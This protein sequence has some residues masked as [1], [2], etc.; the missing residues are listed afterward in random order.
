[1]KLG[2]DTG[3]VVNWMSVGG[4]KPEVG[5][6]VTILHWTDRSAGTIIEVGKN[7]RFVMVQDDKQWRT[8]K[9]GFSEA[10]EWATEPNPEGAVRKYTLRKDGSYR[11]VGSREAL[12][13]GARNPYYDPCF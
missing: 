8:D 2:R 5:M 12:T 6:G 3:S 1:M 13:I 11:L 10:Q 9:N 4:C 7:A